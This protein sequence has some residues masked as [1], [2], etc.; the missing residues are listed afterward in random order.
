MGNLI[1]KPC[2]LMASKDG[3]D[4]I[5]STIY[6]VRASAAATTTQSRASVCQLH[7]NHARTSLWSTASETRVARAL[8]QRRIHPFRAM[9]RGVALSLDSHGLLFRFRSDVLG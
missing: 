6:S 5:N 9:R 3:V 8:F 7:T 1:C 4:A 2:Q